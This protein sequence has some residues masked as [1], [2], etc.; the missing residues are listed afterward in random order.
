MRAG[1]VLEASQEGTGNTYNNTQSRP[2][3]RNHLIPPGPG[4]FPTTPPG[5]RMQRRPLCFHAVHRAWAKR[6]RC[7]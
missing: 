7:F 6:P 2:W 3:R 4:A 5:H 1:S